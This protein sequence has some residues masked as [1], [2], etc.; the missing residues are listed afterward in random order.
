LQAIVAGVGI[1][2]MVMRPA[3]VGRSHIGL[4]RVLLACRVAHDF[5][6]FADSLVWLDVRAGRHFLQIHLHRLR[7]F[8]ALESQCAGWFIAHF[9]L[10][11]LR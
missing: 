6:A 9:F 2:M 7:T 4:D 5:T 1:L 10:D 3:A 11:E 8:F